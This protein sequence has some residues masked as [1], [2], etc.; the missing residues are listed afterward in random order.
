MCVCGVAGTINKLCRDSTLIKVMEVWVGG[1]R[2][3][4]DEMKSWIIRSEWFFVISG[5]K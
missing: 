1:M 4:C 3:K 5:K 2:V